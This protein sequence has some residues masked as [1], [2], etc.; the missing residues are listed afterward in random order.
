M[1]VVYD[2]MYPVSTHVR[3]RSREEALDIISNG[4]TDFIRHFGADY[5]S[6]YDKR[7]TYSSEWEYVLITWAPF[8]LFALLI[9]ALVA[10]V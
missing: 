5:S 1:Y 10:I 9:G 8:C 6:Y 3:A 7:V 2:R 4:R